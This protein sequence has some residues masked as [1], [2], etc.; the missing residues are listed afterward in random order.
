MHCE[1]CFAPLT[2]EDT[3]CKVCGK[4]VEKKEENA[5]PSNEEIIASYKEEPETLI[6]SEEAIQEMS[7]IKPVQTLEPEKVEIKETPN[8]PF[9]VNVDQLDQTIEQPAIEMRPSPAPIV[10]KNDGISKKVFILGIL[11]SIVAT[12]LI[13]ALIFIPITSNKVSQAKKDVESKV[14]TKTVKENRVLL[15]GYSFKIPEGYSYK[16]NGAQLLIQND[17]T[18]VSASLQVGNVDFASIK[19]DLTKLKTN[20][21][22]AK[23]VVG[24]LEGQTIENTI[25]ETVQATVNK[26]NVMIAYTQAGEKTSL[27]IVY[28]DPTSTTYPTIDTLKEFNPIISSLEV[29][30]NT[31]TSNIAT[32]TTNKLFFPVAATQQAQTTKPA[33]TQKTN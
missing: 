16:I 28:V 10:N 30:E 19:G 33:T 29:V 31:F 27:A 26:Q 21:T 18:N 1:N 12:A 20:L 32:F 3:Y 23:W 22:A 25:Y 17:S 11:I 5:Y 2:E 4:T 14:V 9:V 8:D 15:S 24:K 6:P 7:E 13:V